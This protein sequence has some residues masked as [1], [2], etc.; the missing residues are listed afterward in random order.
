VLLEKVKELVT[1]DVYPNAGGELAVI[2]KAFARRDSLTA[3]TLISLLFKKLTFKDTSDQW[4]GGVGKFIESSLAKWYEEAKMYSLNDGLPEV[5]FSQYI[6]VI[7]NILSEDINAYKEY[8]AKINTLL[9]LLLADK[10]K[11]S[12]AKVLFQSI[13]LGQLSFN[14]SMKVIDEDKIIELH[15]EIGEFDSKKLKLEWKVHTKEGFEICRELIQFIGI[16]L[17]EYVLSSSESNEVIMIWFKVIAVVVPSC[18]PWIQKEGTTDFNFTL[19][20][21]RK[22]TSNNESLIEFFKTLR[23]QLLGLALKVA[24]KVIPTLINQTNQK[25]ANKI[26]K[27]LLSLSNIDYTHSEI[28]VYPKILP[29]DKKTY[30]D[31]TIKN[32][33]RKYMFYYRKTGYLLFEITRKLQRINE[34]SF[35]ELKDSLHCLLDTLNFII[36]YVIFVK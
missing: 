8:K 33:V 25:F 30:K 12:Q 19:S 15:K 24:G 17:G 13:L 23:R 20:I 1:S 32:N 36:T 31:P 4:K 34:S 2:V 11:K 26:F 16:G 10:G 29:I 3:N 27:C 22:A 28:E 6:Q 14:A 21:L 35:D 7:G 18:L 9:A 5:K